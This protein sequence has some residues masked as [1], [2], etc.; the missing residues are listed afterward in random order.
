VRYIDTLTEKT[1]ERANSI[2]SGLRQRFPD[3]DVEELAACPENLRTFGA[4]DGKTWAQIKS[5][6]GLMEV[7]WPQLRDFFRAKNAA[8]TRAEATARAQARERD[9][10]AESRT[11]GDERATAD[12][13]AAQDAFLRAFPDGEA[14]TQILQR[15]KPAWVSNVSAEPGRSVAID[16][17]YRS[18]GDQP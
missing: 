2:F 17:W 6:H 3:D 4:P 13:R 8:K 14:Q 12:A 1:R 7:A 15:F 16:A 5:P 10:L 18:V 11:A 9:A